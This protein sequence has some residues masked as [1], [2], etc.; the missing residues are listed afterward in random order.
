MAVRM[1]I[2][3]LYIV[4]L[5]LYRKTF[6]CF[7]YCCFLICN[8]SF[9]PRTFFIFYATRVGVKI[10]EIKCSTLYFSLFLVTK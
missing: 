8:L 6:V 7:G 4:G 1:I 5:F 10:A 2:G 9:F 3:P